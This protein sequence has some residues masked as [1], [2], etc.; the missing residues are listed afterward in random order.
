MLIYWL[1]MPIMHNEGTYANNNN[2]KNAHGG[3]ENT[4]RIVTVMPIDYLIILYDEG[5][6]NT[7]ERR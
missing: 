5:K 1:V 2:Q 6:T 4:K 7:K 3:T